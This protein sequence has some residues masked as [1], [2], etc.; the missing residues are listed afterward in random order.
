MAKKTINLLLSSDDG[1]L[2]YAPTLFVNFLTLHKEFEVTLYAFSDFIS[3]KNRDDLTKIAN[4]YHAKFIFIEIPEFEFAFMSDYPGGLVGWPK[5][6]YY[7]LLAGKYLP[8]DVDRILKVDLDVMFFRSI[9]NFYFDDFENKYLIGWLDLEPL[10]DMSDWLERDLYRKGNPVNAGVLLLNVKKMRKNNLEATFFQ[11]YIDTE[12]VPKGNY[13]IKGNNSGRLFFADQGLINAALRTQLVIKD[14]L[15]VIH[16]SNAH[17]RAHY[18][19]AAIVHFNHLHVKPH[20]SEPGD[21]IGAPNP[22][23]YWSYHYYKL[24]ALTIT[25]NISA[26]YVLNYFNKSFTPRIAHKDFEIPYAVLAWQRVPSKFLASYLN[27]ERRMWRLNFYFSH[28]FEKKPQEYVVKLTFKS[29]EAIS[30]FNFIGYYGG[31]FQV[32]QSL[33]VVKDE[34]TVFEARI[35]FGWR[36]YSGVGFSNAA[37]DVI[38]TR[39]DV[40]DLTIEES[41]AENEERT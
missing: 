9:E 10:V 15:D 28:Y 41:V 22:D 35:N 36:D 29:S 16:W 11:N 4:K 21:L 20:K 30:G 27:T 26:T 13:T 1:Y 25:Q 18:Q 8:H 7:Y 34:L 39:I 24:E 38:G 23:I 17:Y 40:I 5:H 19:K 14:N 2:T 33:N 6:L 32:L 31:R 37:M 12:I 3:K